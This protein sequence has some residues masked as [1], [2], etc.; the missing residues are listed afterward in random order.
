MR[1]TGGE[2]TLTH[3]GAQTLG[4]KNVLQATR[5]YSNVCT[6]PCDNHVHQ[7]PGSAFSQGHDLSST[8]LV[9]GASIRSVAVAVESNQAWPVAA[10]LHAS[11][12]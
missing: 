6:P 5:P 7:A 8:A 9:S 1:A 4:Y 11:K 10:M 2:A 3:P 12:A